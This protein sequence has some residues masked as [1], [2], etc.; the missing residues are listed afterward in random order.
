MPSNNL[1]LQARNLAR[2]HPDGRRWLLEDVSLEIHAGTPL[3]ITG[4]SGTGKTLLLRA[5]AMLDRLDR[6]QICWRGRPPRR[7]GIPEFRRMA[8]YLHQRPALL[9]ETVEAALRRPLTLAAHR[10]RPFDRDRI[11]GWLGQLQ[12]DETFLAKRSGELSGGETQ[13]VA[14]LRAIQLDPTVLLLDE[15]TSAVDRQ[16]TST[17]ERVLQDWVG[18][19]TS[20]RGMIW[21]T[22]D[23]QQARRV[24]RR[25]LWMEDGRINDESHTA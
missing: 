24:A 17:V 10:R 16:T 6:G 3:A 22:H 25:T 7:E 1:L 2:R 4:A 19:P 11:V 8:I 9:E 20:A 5:L 23:A 21:V 12:R 13:I 14:L 18:D 15:P